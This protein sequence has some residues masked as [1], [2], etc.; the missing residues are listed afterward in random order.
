MKYKRFELAIATLYIFFFIIIQSLCRVAFYKEA[1]FPQ[2]SLRYEVRTSMLNNIYNYAYFAAH[3]AAKQAYW[4][5]R[6]QSAL[7][8]I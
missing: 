4:R 1:G 3:S 8:I 6:T 7:N 5:L 2:H